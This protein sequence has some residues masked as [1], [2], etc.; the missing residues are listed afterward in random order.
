MAQESHFTRGIKAEKSE[1]ACPE[2]GIYKGLG[3]SDAKP[4]AQRQSPCGYSE[5]WVLGTSPFSAL[6]EIQVLSVAPR[7]PLVPFT[8]LLCPQVGQSRDAEDSPGLDCE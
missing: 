7:T 5:S 6:L 1:A 4:R 3:P 8:C 2:P